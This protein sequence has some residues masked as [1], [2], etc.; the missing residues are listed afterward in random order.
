METPAHK[1]GVFPCACQTSCTGGDTFR[2]RLAHRVPHGP[3]DFRDRIRWR[4]NG[5][6]LWMPGSWPGV[7]SQATGAH[8]PAIGV[9]QL[10]KEP[11]KQR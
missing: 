9:L 10:Q 6:L 3:P 4:R 11:Y 1:A 8:Q 2:G 5:S 7:R